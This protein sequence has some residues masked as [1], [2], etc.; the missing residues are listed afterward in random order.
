VSIIREKDG[1]GQVTEVMEQ[2]SDGIVRSTQVVVGPANTLVLHRS[3]AAFSYF[4]LVFSLTLP[5]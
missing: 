5:Y 2:W 4:R 1:A 3:K